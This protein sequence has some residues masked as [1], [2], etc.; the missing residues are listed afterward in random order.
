MYNARATRVSKNTITHV[1]SGGGSIT[2]CG[3]R[4]SHGG[5]P[6]AARRRACAHGAVRAAAFSEGVQTCARDQVG[7]YFIFSRRVT[8][9]DCS[10]SHPVPGSERGRGRRK[11]NTNKQIS[12][13][14]MTS[15]VAVRR[16]P[17]SAL[18]SCFKQLEAPKREWRVVVIL[19]YNYYDRRRI[20]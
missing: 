9:G 5:F 19:V 12:T 2:A 14:L 11:I 7:N 4:P 16:D 13:V 17:R 20:I 15:A 10:S 1:G 6:G 3:G 8:L 18:Q